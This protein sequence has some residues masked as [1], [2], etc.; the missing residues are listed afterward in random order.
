MIRHGVL[1]TALLVTATTT[2]ARQ[3]CEPPEGMPQVPCHKC[4]NLEENVE[5]GFNR[6]FEATQRSVYLNSELRTHGQVHFAL[7]YPP[8]ASRGNLFYSAIVRSPSYRITNQAAF[9]RALATH[10][11]LTQSLSF[12]ASLTGPTLTTSTSV[13]RSQTQTL[14]NQLAVSVSHG[15]EPYIVVLYDRNHEEIGRTQFE[16]LALAPTDSTL[17]SEAVDREHSQNPRFQVLGCGWVDPRHNGPTRPA[18]SR[19]PRAPSEPLGRSAPRGSYGLTMTCQHWDV[20][21]NGDSDIRRELTIRC[22]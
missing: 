21:G 12:A 18:P 2:A 4:G 9:G 15:T 11:A 20:G 19:D 8:H 10:Q 5:R 13:V 6:A 14:T 16:Q 7:A 1:A 3:V 22:S 17:D